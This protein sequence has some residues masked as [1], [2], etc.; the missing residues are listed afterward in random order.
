LVYLIED[1]QKIA[2]TLLP[3][4]SLWYYGYGPGAESQRERRTRE[5][6]ER[7]RVPL[8]YG[9]PVLQF[10]PETL[11]NLNLGPRETNIYE[12]IDLAPYFRN[13]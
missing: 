10:N 5:S 9:D 11:I 4:D 3:Y 12:P 13:R 7:G 1:A 2:R 8:I 6:R